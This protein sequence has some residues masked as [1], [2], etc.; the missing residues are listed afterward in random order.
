MGNNFLERTQSALGEELMKKFSQYKYCVVGCGGTGALFAE[1]LARTGA[2]KISLIDGDAVDASNLNRVISFVRDDVG[3][4]KVDVLQSRLR[5]INPDI[6]ITAINCYFREHDPNDA[7]GQGARDEVC[8]ADIIVL[9][10]DQNEYRIL[11]EELCYL[12]DKNKKLISVGVQVDGPGSA[13]YE[14]SWCRKTPQKKRKEEG[15]GIG[16]YASIVIEATA[17]AFSMLLHNLMNPDLSG[18]NYF[19]KSYKNFDP[20]ISTR[21]P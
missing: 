14:C 6:E 18:F 21:K 4:S 9:A 8:N 2:R 17:V 3:N 11:C 13:S 1:M 12:E 19:Y 7:D 5:N 16:S 10:V 20:E 15:Y